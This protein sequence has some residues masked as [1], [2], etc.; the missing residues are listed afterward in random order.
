MGGQ[1]GL[2]AVGQQAGPQATA[3]LEHLAKV[4]AIYQEN[5]ASGDLGRTK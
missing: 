3:K 1:A 5:D 2:W 4:Y